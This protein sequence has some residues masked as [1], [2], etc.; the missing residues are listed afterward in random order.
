MEKRH[1]RLFWK[2]SLWVLLGLAV[3]AGLVAGVVAL[4]WREDRAR[5]LYRDVIT[6]EGLQYDLLRAGQ[7]GVEVS[8]DSS[9]DPV[10]IGDALFLPS[11]GVTIVVEHR[12]D[13]Y[14]VQGTN[15]YGDETLWKCV[16]GTG[17]RPDLGGLEVDR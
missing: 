5:P 10:A 7:E 12:D 1:S 17:L 11:S 14:C 3:I 15:Q 9:S 6:M 2:E 8:V 16:D 13:A 4:D